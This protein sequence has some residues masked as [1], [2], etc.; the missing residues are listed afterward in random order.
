MLQFHFERKFKTSLF[1]KYVSN[2]DYSNGRIKLKIEHILRVSKICKDIAT[3][4]NLTE[5][6]SVKLQNSINTIKDN[7]KSLQD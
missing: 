1:L 6:E 4:L 5:E 3:N 2:Y 7:I